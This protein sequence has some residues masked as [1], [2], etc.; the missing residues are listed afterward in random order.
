MVQSTPDIGMNSVSR[1]AIG[2]DPVTLFGAPCNVDPPFSANELRLWYQGCQNIPSEVWLRTF[3]ASPNTKTSSS[4]P[5]R[6]NN[7]VSSVRHSSRG[8]GSAENT[9]N[10]NIDSVSSAARGRQE[11]RSNSLPV[12]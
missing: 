4:N 5:A 3:F 1:P 9:H 8:G 10:N 2:P 11:L 12:T 7:R 6:Q